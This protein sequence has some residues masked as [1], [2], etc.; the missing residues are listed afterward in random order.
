MFC[1]KKN[2]FSYSVI[3]FVTKRTINLTNCQIPTSEKSRYSIIYTI[4]FEAMAIQSGKITF[5]KSFK[6]STS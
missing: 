4:I 1:V 3:A 2:F 6:N 5:G